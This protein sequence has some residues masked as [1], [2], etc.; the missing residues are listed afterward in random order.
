MF[1][2]RVKTKIKESEVEGIGLFADQFILK[3][4]M[5]W[6]YD[7]EYDPSYTQAQVDDMSHVAREWFMVYGYFDHEQNRY[8]LCAD[9]QR[10]I[11]HSD[12][13]C[14][15]STPD[16]DVAAKDIQ[17]GEEMT[18]DYTLYE[19]DWFERRGIKRNEFSK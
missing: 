11:N 6:Q 8:V 9:N 5:T 17:I 15:I 3:G 13:P 1:M 19:H 10:H 4:T 7:S 2:L 12:T 18:C 14:I 16:Y